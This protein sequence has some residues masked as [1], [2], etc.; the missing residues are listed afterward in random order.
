LRAAD[1]H[2]LVPGL[3]GREP[4]QHE[5]L[6]RG[7]VLIIGPGPIVIDLVVVEAAGEGASGVDGDQAGI[8]LVLGV[9]TTIVVEAVDLAPEMLARGGRALSRGRCDGPAA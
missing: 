7:A 2:V 3:Q 5:D 1:R 8:A 4:A 9:A 6:G